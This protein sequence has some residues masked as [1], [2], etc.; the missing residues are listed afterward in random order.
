VDGKSGSC[1][2]TCVSASDCSADEACSPTGHCVA[3]SCTTD[4]ECPS[5]QTVDYACSAGSCAVKSCQ[6]N[7]DCGA[8]YCVSGTCYPQQGMCVPPAD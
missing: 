1:I 5:T 8:H 2:P 3:K 4:A 6:T 7:T